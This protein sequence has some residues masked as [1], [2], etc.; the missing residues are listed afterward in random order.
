MEKSLRDVVLPALDPN[1]P[2]AQ[3]QLNLAIDYLAFLRV[4]LDHMLPRLRFELAHYRQ[5]ARSV[6]AASGALPVAAP[7]LL[8]C[9]RS[10]LL[11]ADIDAS[12]EDYRATIDALSQT[13]DEVV[14]V[15]ATETCR[16]AVERAVLE[17]TDHWIDLELSWY[18]PIAVDPD[19]E[20]VRPLADFFPYR[21][22]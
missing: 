2:L 8:L 21:S 6:V 22:A 16:G 10:E 18:S 13:I 11:S 3:E 12:A 20:G 4:R 1:D 5:M 15:C 19:A 7:L 9:E 17:T 14:A